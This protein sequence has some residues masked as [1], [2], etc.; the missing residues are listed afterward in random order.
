MESQ[1][2]NQ[3]ASLKILIEGIK[4]AQKKG[5]YTLEESSNLWNA[6]KTFIDSDN[7]EQ[8]INNQNQNQNQ[9]SDNKEI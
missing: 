6:I 7:Q 4:I 3:L 5:A 8:T 9:N 2:N 1:E